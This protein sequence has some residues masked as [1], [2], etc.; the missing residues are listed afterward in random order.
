MPRRLLACAA[1]LACATTAHAQ[2][3]RSQLG[4]LLTFG[5]W[6]VPLRVGTLAPG[7]QAVVPNDA[8]A[9]DANAA[10]GG[11]LVDWMTASAASVPL[12]ATGG[13]RTFRFAGGVPVADRPT[14]GPIFGERATT[15]GRG[16]VLAGV[17]YTGVRYTRVRGVPLDALRLTLTQG[18]A[19][20]ARGDAIALRAALGYD[21]A[22]AA[23][24]ATAGVLDRVDVGVVV[25]VVR[26][27]LTGE[28]TA[29][30]VPGAGGAPSTVLGGTAA[31]PLLT[32]QQRIGGRAAGLGDVAL[33]AKVNVVDRPAGG[34]GL[35]G[36]VR[37]PTGD[38][39]DLL[40][41]GA[42]SARLLAVYAGR[43]G[44]VTPHANVGYLYFADRGINDAVLATVGVD[45]DMAPWATVSLSLLG[46]F[47]PGASAYRLPAAAAGAAPAANV[48][49]LRDDALSTSIGAKFGRGGTRALANVLAPVTRGGPRPDLAYTFG[50]ERAF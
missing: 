25:P 22:V 38:A 30:V 48:P 15:L 8:F 29:S 13:G 7:G 33:R 40:G 4:G 21:M 36:D 28:S 26:T 37:L 20:G 39:D 14:P 17:N 49:A 2:K 16:G 24:Y 44:G 35:L 31:A 34:F 6:G 32:T 12:A 10:L 5:D 46:Q 27:R 50:L 19:A 43:F 18:G 11:F 41:S 47:H 1:L 3:L 45:A 42:V 9:V 23:F